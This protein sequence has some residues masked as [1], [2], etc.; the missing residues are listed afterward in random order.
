M[1]TVLYIG[2]RKVRPFWRQPFPIPQ[3]ALF[4]LFSFLFFSFL[5]NYSPHAMF[6]FFWRS[7]QS[8]SIS[9]DGG[10][11]V[12][13][14]CHAASPLR[15]SVSS[16]IMVEMMEIF[17]ERA[18]WE[19]KIVIEWEPKRASLE[20]RRIPSLSYLTFS[21]VPLC[22]STFSLILLIKYY[23]SSTF[24]HAHGMGIIVMLWGTE[25]HILLRKME[26]LK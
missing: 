7:N 23:K 6:A 17:G 12:P 18:Y 3:I 26:I 24:L 9:F 21:S 10:N 25:K 4:L 14:D 20:A 1:A 5:L 22:L 13:T 2:L 15:A 11:D 8:M 16:Y 19:V